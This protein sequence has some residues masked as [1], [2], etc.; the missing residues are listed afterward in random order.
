MTVEQRDF[1]RKHKSAAIYTGITKGVPP[2]ITLAQAIIESGWGKYAICNNFFGIKAHGGWTGDTCSSQT[3]E[4]GSGGYYQI[5]SSFRAYGSARASFKDHAQ[6]LIDNSRYHFLFSYP[7]TDYV[8]WAH[9]LKQAG[10]ATAPNYGP[11]LI[12]AIEKYGL[13]RFD[14]YVTISKVISIVVIIAFI[15]F[16]VY[17]FKYAKK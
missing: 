11:T 6:F 13:Q 8:N 14:K 12:N 17:K 10:Y 16:L 2:S 4:Y 3:N 9:G 7:I 5:T 15:T 1:I